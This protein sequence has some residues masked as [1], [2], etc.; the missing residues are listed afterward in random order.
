[1]NDRAS[2]SFRLLLILISALL[3]LQ[4]A[5]ISPP[6]LRTLTGTLATSPDGLLRYRIP[7][8]WFDV[9][10]D[11]QATGHRIWLVS[12][13]LGA[14][15]AV[16]EVHIDAGIRTRLNQGLLRE[17]ARLLLTLRAGREG[18]V[19]L[20]SPEWTALNGKKVCV[21]RLGKPS[22]RET[23]RIA[24]LDTG[25]KL[26][27]TTLVMTEREGRTRQ[28]KLLDAQDQFVESLQW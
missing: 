25:R 16:D 17:V 12:D 23:H 20:S 4:C 28:E 8:G 1:M 19:E 21:Y 2:G 10:A 13:D 15:I 11:S 14:T 9:S 7:L 18:L 24:L 6:P 27:M 22:T 3:S 5:T 26:Y